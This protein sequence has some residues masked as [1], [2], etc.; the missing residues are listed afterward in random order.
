MT[1]RSL[2][3]ALLCASAL[4]LTPDSASPPSKLDTKPKLQTE[5]QPPPRL[6]VVSQH[7]RSARLAAPQLGSCACSGRAWRLWAGRLA[8]GPGPGPD[9]DPDPDPDSDPT[10]ARQVSAAGLGLSK[11]SPLKCYALVRPYIKNPMAVPKR[12]LAFLGLMLF[13]FY[14]LLSALTSIVRTR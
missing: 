2:V 10:V 7:D 9:P 3:L 12:I 14:M 13:S 1:L 8:P 6:G 5:P 11:L 4:A